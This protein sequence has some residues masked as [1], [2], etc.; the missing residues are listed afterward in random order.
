M[1]YNAAVQKNE[2]RRYH[3]RTVKSGGELYN[4]VVEGKVGIRRE[5]EP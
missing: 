5:V 3:D 4:G 1:Q 2:R